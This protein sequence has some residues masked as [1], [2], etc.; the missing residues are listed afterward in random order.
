MYPEEAQKQVAEICKDFEKTIEASKS[1]RVDIR[2]ELVISIDSAR[3]KALDDALS[4]WDLGEG[5]YRVGI[6]IADPAQLIEIDSLLDKE[7]SKRVESTYVSD[8]FH[9]PMLP[10]ELNSDKCSINYGENRFAITLYADLDSQGMIDF[11]TVKYESTILKNTMRL[12]YL[13][14]DQLITSTTDDLI[15]GE[16]RCS[17]DLEKTVKQKL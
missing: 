4:F 11:S 2:E 17:K 14:A 1:S 12:T 15:L 10:Q 16:E 7:A 5:K 6:H 9:V 8:I 3:T 13:E